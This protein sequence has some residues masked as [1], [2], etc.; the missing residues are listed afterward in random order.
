M[1]RKT[2]E[3]F[4][5]CKDR[6]VSLFKQGLSY[7]KIG[8]LLNL[9]FATVQCVI[10]K[11]KTTNSMENSKRLGRPR[12]LYTRDSRNLVQQVS[13]NPKT[14]A[15]KLA[16]DLATAT[17]KHVSL[18]T[19]RNRLH[20]SGNKKTF[21]NKRNRRKRLEFARAYVN[22]P[23]DFWKTVLFS[24][25]KF[26]TFGSDGPQYVWRKPKRKENWIKEKCYTN[27]QT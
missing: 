13:R 7:R 11:I 10:K 18:Q 17:S 25:S 23:I 19:I 27:S 3:L 14:S 1:G 6:I 15:R 22:K 21:I 26:N 2:K 4:L 5:V 20:E 24:E 16:E 8:T 9:S 12:V